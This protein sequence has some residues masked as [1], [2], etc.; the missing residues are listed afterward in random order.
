MRTRRNFEI[1]GHGQHNR[2]S[3]AWLA[4]RVL[5]R[6]NYIVITT[7]GVIWH[8]H[9]GREIRRSVTAESHG[10]HGRSNALRSG[11]RAGIASRIDLPGV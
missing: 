5:R 1:L 10:V 11:Q 8:V 4:G 2:E 9:R 6:D 7:V 3:V